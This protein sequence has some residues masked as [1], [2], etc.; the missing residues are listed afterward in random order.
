MTENLRNVYHVFQNMHRLKHLWRFSTEEIEKTRQDDLKICLIHAIEKVPYYRKILEKADRKKL[1][2]NPLEFLREMPLLT[3]EIAKAQFPDQLVAEGNNWEHF[4]SV[5]TSGTTDRVMIF[6]DEARRNWDRAADLLLQRQGNRFYPGQRS[7]SFPPD[8]CYE[9]CGADGR[10]LVYSVK[11]R[12]RQWRKAAPED[13]RK[14][15]RE[16]RS[17]IMS[18]YIWRSRRLPS[19]GVDGTAASDEVL[20]SYCEELKNWKPRIISGLPV[21]LYVLAL[22]VIR[23]GYS[24]PSVRVIR[25]NG[26]KFSHVMTEVVEK[27]FGACIRENYGSAELSTMALDC[28]N[29][30][31][32]HLL[33][34]HFLECLR[35]GQPVEPGEV[36]ELVITDLR[37]RVT[38]LIRYTLGDVGRVCSGRCSCGFEG[39]RFIVDG[40]M[41]E[42]IVTPSGKAIPGV[43]LVDLFLRCKAIDHVKI[44][45]KNDD[46]FLVEAVL[47]PD[48]DQES[49]KMEEALSNLLDH[50]VRLKFRWVQRIAPERNGKY[51]LVVSSSYQRFHND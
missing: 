28:E 36:G 37:N 1:Q 35:R 6:E 15:K 29:S 27:A 8:A 45:Q 44:F 46:L 20:E 5:A 40:R 7:L 43:Q 4:Y 31:D 34:I 21:T 23:H 47:S 25:P 11:D 38:P 2:E 9:H 14:A 33:G 50:R 17:K 18:E 48:A 24:F 39:T 51:R 10:M 26:A 16:L 22:Y 3:K 13:R 41:E 12:F 49:V 30:R 19:L 32:Q 42:T